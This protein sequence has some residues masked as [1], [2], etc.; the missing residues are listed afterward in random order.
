M[1]HHIIGLIGTPAALLAVADRAGAPA[2]TP[3]PFDLAIVPL[4]GKQLDRLTG[5]TASR[6]DE[7]FLCLSAELE[8]AI[9]AAATDGR[10]LYIE[11]DYFGGIGG[12]G[13]ALFEEGALAWTDSVREGTQGQ[14]KSPISQGL[15]H[16]GIPPAPGSDEFDAVGLVRF[17]NMETL[18]L[19][20]DDDG[21]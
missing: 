5:E 16:L 7:N 19:I 13:A 8:A 1:G 4:G 21:D 2:P 18:G 17:R 9:G 6:Y 10:L 3:L 20:D 15:S 12:Q 11:T 14:G